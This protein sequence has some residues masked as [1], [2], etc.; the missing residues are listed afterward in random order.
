MLKNVRKS[1]LLY[2]STAVLMDPTSEKT[3]QVK[4]AALP[5]YAVYS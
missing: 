1:I 4:I 3:D 5:R 2:H